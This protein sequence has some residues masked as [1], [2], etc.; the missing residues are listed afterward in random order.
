MLAEFF[1]IIQLSF[2]QYDLRQEV[3]RLSMKIL[4][5]LYR[6]C[7]DKRVKRCIPAAQRHLNQ[8]D[9]TVAQSSLRLPDYRRYPRDEFSTTNSFNIRANTK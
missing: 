4:P 1:V 5:Y 8:T 3:L 9:G 2:M 7:S 6:C